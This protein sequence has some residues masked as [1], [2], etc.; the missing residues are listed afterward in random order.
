MK[1]TKQNLISHALPILGTA[2]IIAGIVLEVKSHYDEQARLEN[3]MSEI[4]NRYIR[5]ITSPDDFGLA[6]SLNPELGCKIAGDY[7]KEYSFVA[8]ELSN[9]ELFIAHCSK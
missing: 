1:L 8:A 7:A 5:G 6:V 4:V 3:V 9:S 2:L